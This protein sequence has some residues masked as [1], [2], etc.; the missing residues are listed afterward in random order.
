MQNDGKN[1]TS[2]T[3]DTVETSGSFR[4]VSLADRL[5]SVKPIKGPVG[6]AYAIRR[7]Y[8]SDDAYDFDEEWA[9]QKKQWH[10]EEIKE[11]GKDYEI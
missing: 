3:S 5:V 4:A 11:A 9:K 6:L 1:A 10:M 8:S 7:V 2:T